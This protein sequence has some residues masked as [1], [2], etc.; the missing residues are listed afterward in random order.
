MSLYRCQVVLPPKMLSAAPVAACC[1]TSGVSVLANPLV[2]K[3]SL[4]SLADL[5]SIGEGWVGQLQPK[6]ALD[7]MGVYIQS[8]LEL[9]S[10]G[11]KSLCGDSALLMTLLFL[12]CKQCQKNNM[13][14]YMGYFAGI[15]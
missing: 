4:T 2:T 11:R 15:Q 12:S 6:I 1:S 5:D 8:S 14:L 13:L 3:W 10:Q 7:R 9:R